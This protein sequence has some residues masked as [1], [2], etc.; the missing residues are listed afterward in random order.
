MPSKPST[1]QRES[2]SGGTS[3]SQ[4]PK[5]NH[6]PAEKPKKEDHDPKKGGMVVHGYDE[7]TVATESGFG[8]PHGLPVYYG[9]THTFPVGG[10][11]LENLAKPFGINSAF[12]IVP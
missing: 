1:P 7:P 10:N 12:C 3:P 11:Q 2:G 8:G 9:V 5:Q 6:G 4:P